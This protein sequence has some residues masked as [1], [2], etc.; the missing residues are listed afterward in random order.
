MCQRLCA[1]LLA[2][3]VGEADLRV[4]RVAL[5]H[6]AGQSDTVEVPFQPPADRQRLDADFR[7]HHQRIY[8][9]ATDEPWEIDSL[10][11]TARGPAARRLEDLTPAPARGAPTPIAV[12][13]C[14]FDAD[15]ARD[16]PR[17][18]RATLAPDVEV[19]GPCI[20]EDAWSTVVVDPG[21]RVHVDALG[22]L[23]VHLGV[24]S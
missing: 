18:E 9:F 13:Q 16:T 5:I 23:H 14:W 17:F 10:R 1:P 15:G 11:I 24:A 12:A 8:G 7:D 4:D 20:I 22:H 3:G 19:P 2:A 21:S 6:Y